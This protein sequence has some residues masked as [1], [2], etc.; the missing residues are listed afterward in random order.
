MSHGL[1]MDFSYTFSKSIDM[2][3]DAE[4]ASSTGGYTA[5]SEIIDAWNPYKN[6]GPSD[7][8]TRHV[9]TA[10]WVYNLPFGRGKAFAGNS[11][12]IL[13]GIVGGWQL[14]GLT[15]WTSGLPFSIQNGAGWGT[16]WN[17]RSYMVQTGPIDT[18]RHIN[19]NGSPEAFADP[20]ALQADISAGTPW[21]MPYAGEVGSRN[22]FRGDGYFGIDSGLGKSWKITEVQALKF[23][24]EVFNVTNSVRFDTNPNTSLD[25]LSTD[26]SMGV[27]SKT[28]TAPR[29][30]QFSLR[31]AF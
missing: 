28:L 16:N 19:A 30:Q 24:W 2:G 25:N 3:S 12:G 29:V 6:R 23:T 20:A 8:D 7:F 1:Q 14:S 22:N 21:R 10:D 15:R 17:F 31:Y 4:R 18:H 26:G 5:F 13:Q 11:G 9:I 27:Y